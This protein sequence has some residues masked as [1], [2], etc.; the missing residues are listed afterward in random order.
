MRKTGRLAPDESAR[1]RGE[2]GVTVM[3][4]SALTRVEDDAV[5]VVV[6][7]EL[8]AVDED[9]VGLAVLVVKPPTTS[10][11]LPGMPSSAVMIGEAVADDGAGPDD[12]GEGG[13]VDVDVAGDLELVVVGARGRRRWLGLESSLRLDEE[14]RCWLF[15]VVGPLWRM[16][17]LVPGV[18]APPSASEVT[19]PTVPVPLQG[20]AGE[21]D[22][23][24]VPSTCRVPALMMVMPV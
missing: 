4:T 1:W 10:L 16:P 19:V 23:P 22:V 18:D 15:Q 17:G 14:G 5:G 3:N 2:D 6:D 7:G 20:A 8:L 24:M 13:A 9:R 12:A 11:P 21:D